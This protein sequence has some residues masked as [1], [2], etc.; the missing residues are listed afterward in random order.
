[1]DDLDTWNADTGPDSDRLIFRGGI[2]GAI[3]PLGLFLTG[4]AW[5]GLSGAPD[6]KGFWAI[7][8][9][10]ITLGTF[11]AKDPRA[12]S[13]AVIKGMS[14]PIVMLMVFAWILAGVLGSLVKPR[15]M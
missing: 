2:L 14:R 9:V 7:L 11:L 8:L 4:V 12:Y 6:E 1:M 3:A 5:L 13:D 10:A 15:T